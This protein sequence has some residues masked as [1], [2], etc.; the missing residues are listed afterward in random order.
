MDDSV[1]IFYPWT[2]SLH[3]LPWKISVTASALTSWWTRS[4]RRNVTAPKSGWTNWST[5]CSRSSPPSTGSRSSRGS[6][7]GKRRKGTSFCKPG[8][9]FYSSNLLLNQSCRS[10]LTFSS[11]FQLLSFQRKLR[12]VLKYLTVVSIWMITSP[13]V[14][15][16]NTFFCQ[17]L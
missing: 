16:F 7:K 6:G 15:T 3:M 5:T 13:Q 14:Y 8:R 2:F 9:N 4:H 1:L 12:T 10:K 11:F 17:I